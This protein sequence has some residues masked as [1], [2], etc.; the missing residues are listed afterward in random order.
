MDKFKHIIKF[1]LFCWMLLASSQGFAGCWLDTTKGTTAT[2]RYSYNLSHAAITVSRNQTP[3]T[4]VSNMIS[5]SPGT[6]TAYVRCDAA[7]MNMLKIETSMTE[8]ALFPDIYETNVPGIGVKIWDDYS[9]PA[10]GTVNVTLG[11]DLRYWYNWRNRQ[12]IDNIITNIKIQFYAI[13]PVTAGNVQMSSP[14][15]GA[16]SNTSV[17]DAGAVNYALLDITGAVQIKVRACKTPDIT[18]NLGK[19]QRSEFTGLNATTSATPFVFAINDCD[20]GLNSVNYT[21]KPASGIMVGGSG[22]TE[23]I[24]L[25]SASTA[26]GVG[27]QVLYD[28]GA[29]N[30]L[31]P[32]NQKTKFTGYN[33][34]LGGSYTIPMKARYI[35]TAANI[36]GGTANSAIEFTMSYE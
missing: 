10:Y 11:N 6:V 33:K 3:G 28:S 9:Y 4:T 18:V 14:T 17:S 16:W 36:S 24:T 31:V 21:F 13:G 1:I 35:Q 34:T 29:G 15:V 25:D 23:H 26:N 8:S 7:G 27:I 5:V 19:H 32:L 30:T 22:T 20:P 2:T 12:D